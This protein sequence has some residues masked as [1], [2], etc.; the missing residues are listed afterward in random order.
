MIELVELL[1]HFGRWLADR[2][3]QM[4]LELAI[5]AAVVLAVI[6]LLRVRSP[7]VRH[8]LRGLVLAK[9]V[10]MFLVVGLLGLPTAAERKTQDPPGDKPGEKGTAMGKKAMPYGFR[11]D[12]M[13]FVEKS[14]SVQAALVRKLV[15]ATP[16]A[17]DKQV[18]G[19]EVGAVLSGQKPDGGLVDHP[20]HSVALTGQKLMQLLDLGA[21]PDDPRMKRAI[22]Y[23]LR[24]AA[25]TSPTS[26]W[27]STTRTS[28]AASAAPIRPAFARRTAPCWPTRRAG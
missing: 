20:L 27:G 13:S 16:A 4:S 17:G 10:V 25:R 18:L 7:A 28:S 24:T 26:R 8:A 22:D 19:A 3:W 2:L 1:N 5:L 6:W 14:G 11:H 12:P 21:S 15:L 9:P 23:V